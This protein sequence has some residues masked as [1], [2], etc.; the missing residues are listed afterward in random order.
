MTLKVLLAD[1][2]DMVRS[3]FALI[4]SMEDDIEVVG[5]ARNGAEA[6]DLAEA[7]RPD[8]V[9]M[10]VQMP[11]MD[12]ITATAALTEKLP[13]T[14]V[15][16]LTTFDREDYLFSSLQAGASGF[17][18]K[19]SDADELVEA[20]R[21]VAGGL[22]LL[23][24]EMTLP[25]IARFVEQTKGQDATAQAGSL[26]ASKSGGVR[27]AQEL[28]PEDAFAL[29]ALTPREKET[30]ELLAQ[31]LTNAEIAEKLFLGAATVKTHVSNILAKTHS[32]DRVGAVIFAHRVGL[33]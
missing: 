28:S 13:G 12:G 19:T 26:G 27:S 22:A 16:I 18:L 11:V 20:I 1:D 10:D 5:Q 15:L 9:L 21:K 7:T 23:S 6:L 29:G 32:R 8:V 25:L 2:Q 4:L 14:S 24:P 17:L 3:G 30:L 31:G 33:A